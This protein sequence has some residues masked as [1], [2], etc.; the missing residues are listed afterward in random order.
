MILNNTV[1]GS[2]EADAIGLWNGSYDTVIGNNVSD[3]TV[4]PKGAQPATS[5]PRLSLPKG[6]PW[7]PY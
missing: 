4:D 6:K 5:R 3:F 1:T 2:D 7:L